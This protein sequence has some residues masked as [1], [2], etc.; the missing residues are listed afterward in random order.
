MKRSTLA[1]ILLVSGV[2]ILLYAMFLM[3]VSTDGRVVNLNLWSIRLNLA[4]I[5]SIAAF[6]GLTV[7]YAQPSVA[8]SNEDEIESPTAIER[9]IKSVRESPI[10]TLRVALL[11]AAPIGAWLI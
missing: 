3:D 2:C 11:G 4:I 1:S 10:Q 9:I 8:R 5:G 7:L 6:A